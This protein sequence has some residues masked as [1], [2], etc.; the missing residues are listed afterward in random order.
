MRNGFSTTQ[1]S[2]FAWFLSEAMSLRTPGSTVA[3]PSHTDHTLA[4]PSSVQSALD[5]LWGNEPWA[6]AIV[7]DR[8]NRIRYQSGHS[9]RKDP[10]CGRILVSQCLGRRQDGRPSQHEDRHQM[11]GSVDASRPDN[12]R[13]GWN[14]SGRGN[15]GHGNHGT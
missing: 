4:L 8:L 6:S 10:R 5:S 11:I 14:L 3:H 13:S 15:P 7:C 2:F 12:L 9:K 1:E